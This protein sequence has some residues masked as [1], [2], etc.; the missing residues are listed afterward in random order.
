MPSRIL[1]IRL[2]A[3][4]DVIMATSILPGLRARYPEARITWLT[5]GLGAEILDQNPLLDEILTLPRKHWRQLR[6][7]GKL[8]S[9]VA[10]LR[11]FAKTLRSQRFDLVI[12]LQGLLKSALWARLSGA[13]RRVILRPRENAH[14]LMTE[15]VADPDGF[16]G[17]LCREYRLI[18]THL[19][20]PP[21]SFGM[22]IHPLPEKIEALRVRIN[23]HPGRPIALLPFTTRPQKHWF[24]PLWSELADR[25][26]ALPDT[27]VWILGG[28]TDAPAA[29]RIAAAA[30]ITPVCIS[31]P[32]T[33]LRDKAAFLSLADLAIGVDTGLTHL[34][35]GLGRPTVALFGS[36]CPYE[37]TDPVPGT[38]LYDRLE[39]SPCRR[40]PTCHGAFTC[41]RNLTV[42]RVFEA[43]RAHLQP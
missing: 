40:H 4:G 41:M 34:A 14:W 12:D 1:I 25:L 23:T 42:D 33:D 28:P 18:A 35:L 7:T 37:R 6:Q 10:S 22:A 20:L 21:K 11:D 27:R 31:G 2:S 43:A 36:T 5:E 26:G 9:L 13:P 19:D 30:R 32:D 3:I 29:E 15:S 16:G 17:P 8:G 38:V 39:C 24:E